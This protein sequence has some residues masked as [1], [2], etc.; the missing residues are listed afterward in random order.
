MFTKLNCVLLKEFPTFNFFY[1]VYLVLMFVFLFI[2]SYLVIDFGK[3]DL[4]FEKQ[5]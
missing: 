2:L 5:L 1:T 4:V 3:V